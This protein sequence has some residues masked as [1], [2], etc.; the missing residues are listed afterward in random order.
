[1]IQGLGKQVLSLHGEQQTMLMTLEP[2]NTGKP[3]I[4]MTWEPGNT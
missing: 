4:L 3:T 2:E 1:M